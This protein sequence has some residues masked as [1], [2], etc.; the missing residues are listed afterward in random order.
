MAADLVP[1]ARARKALDHGLRAQTAPSVH[2]P[3]VP[4]SR[5]RRLPRGRRE[6]TPLPKVEAVLHDDV[7]PRRDDPSHPRD[8]PLLNMPCAELVRQRS[9]GPAVLRKDDQAADAKVEAVH[10]RGPSVAR[11][12]GVLERVQALAWTGHRHARRFR[13]DEHVAVFVDQLREGV[14]ANGRLMNVPQDSDL[15]SPPRHGVSRHRRV[16]GVVLARRAP[17]D[18]AAFDGGTPE[19]LTRRRAAQRLRQRAGHRQ[20][21]HGI[22]QAVV[23]VAFVWQCIA[24]APLPEV[25]LRGGRSGAH[26]WPSG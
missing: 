26:A 24:K 25:D 9:L 18:P 20:P 16:G 17:R 13:Q 7:G 11:P 8:V 1:A 19:G 5:G 21:R 15:V 12:R 4:H 10:R 14:D 6:R 22:V 2:V 23:A 3:Q